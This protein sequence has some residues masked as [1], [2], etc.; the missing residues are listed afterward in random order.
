MYLP[1]FFYNDSN[2]IKKHFHTFVFFLIQRI[3]LFL[4]FV[5]LSN[6]NMLLSQLDEFFPYS[7]M[8]VIE[9]INEKMMRRNPH[10]FDN[11][12]NKKF[13]KILQIQSDKQLSLTATMKILEENTLLYG[14]K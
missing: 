4:L 5:C 2:I 11:K 8:D 13:T 1:L 14:T 3:V 7:S 10:V 12:D 9:S 6:F